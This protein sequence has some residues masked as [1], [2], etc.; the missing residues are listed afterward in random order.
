[1]SSVRGG[2]TLD[3]SGDRGKPHAGLG[4]VMSALSGQDPSP[5]R[6]PVW[7]DMTRYDVVLHARGWWRGLRLILGRRPLRIFSEVLLET[8]AYC[9]RHCPACPVSLAPRGRETMD[10]AV[11]SR[12]L[13]ELGRLR[14]SG[15]IALHFFNEPLLDKD[16]LPKVRQLRQAAPR[17]RIEIHSNGDVLSRELAGELVDVGN[18]IHARDRLQRPRH[19]AHGKDDAD[20]SA[21]GTQPHRRPASPDFIGNRAGSLRHLSIS[22]PLQADCSQPSYR[23]VINHKGEAVICTTTTLPIRSWGTWRISP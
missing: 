18:V 2:D 19:E 1:M 13:E 8:S 16:I 15:R 12:I 11:F 20:L 9:N 6:Y 14:Y 10:E 21:A 22:E 5:K 7:S 4:E 3:I 23:L 17:A